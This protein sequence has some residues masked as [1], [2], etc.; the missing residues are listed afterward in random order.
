MH[1]SQ[2]GCQSV[3][4]SQQVKSEERIVVESSQLV[5]IF[6]VACVCVDAILM[7]KG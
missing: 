2:S 7:S 3:C 1:C 5:K 4:L 6:A